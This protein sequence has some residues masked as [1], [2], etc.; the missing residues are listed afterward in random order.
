MVKTK[1]VMR[2][3]LLEL[4]QKFV[5]EVEQEHLALARLGR[6]RHHYNNNA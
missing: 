3:A 6:E 4:A 5:A 2:Q 1:A